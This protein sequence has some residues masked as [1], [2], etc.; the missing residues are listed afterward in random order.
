MIFDDH[1]ELAKTHWQQLRT[2][3]FHVLP[4]LEAIRCQPPDVN[5]GEDNAVFKT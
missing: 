5:N 4:M 1:Y 2:R 3:G